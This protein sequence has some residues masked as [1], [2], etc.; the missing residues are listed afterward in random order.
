MGSSSMTSSVKGLFKGSESRM[1]KLQDM[2][3]YREVVIAPPGY[4][5]P[6]SAVPFDGASSMYLHSSCS[7]NAC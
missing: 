3:N 2:P 5:S 6:A 4:D 7:V 1:R